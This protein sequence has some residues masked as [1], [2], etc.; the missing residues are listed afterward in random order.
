MY[1][2]VHIMKLIS[3]LMSW[4]IINHHKT[5]EALLNGTWYC[6]VSVTLPEVK[7][8]TFSFDKLFLSRNFLVFLFSLPL[9][10]DPY[11]SAA[12]GN[13]ADN[14]GRT[15]YW[16]VP[17]NLLSPLRSLKCCRTLAGSTSGYSRDW[18]VLETPPGEF[19][20]KAVGWVGMQISSITF[21]AV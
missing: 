2:H 5:H 17:M 9:N 10:P 21:Y 14:W 8:W 20:M 3:A 16:W 1:D 4:G 6:R 18:G 13:E 12:Y 15:C 7:L 11:L 19:A